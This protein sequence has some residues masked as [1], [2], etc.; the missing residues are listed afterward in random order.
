MERTPIESKM[1]KSVGWNDNTLEV[2]FSK[3][4]V[5]HYDNVP[6]SVFNEM[7]N[8]HSKGRFFNEKIKENYTYSKASDS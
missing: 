3:G 7:L 4:T 8:A 1:L 5:Y 2:E 6:E